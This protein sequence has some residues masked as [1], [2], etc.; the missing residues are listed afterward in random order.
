MSYRTLLLLLLTGLYY[1]LLAAGDFEKK[2]IV[3]KNS[4]LCFE[5]LLTFS[6]LS[7][8]LA[9]IS[10]IALCYYILN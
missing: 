9:K 1:T 8:I 7:T 6:V 2:N 5:R 4:S 10:F 3:N